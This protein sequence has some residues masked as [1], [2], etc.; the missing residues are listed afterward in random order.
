[1]PAKLLATASIGRRLASIAY[2]LLLIAAILL[3]SSALYTPIKAWANA[4]FWLDQLFRLFLIGIL[5]AYFGVCW[6]THGQ[7]VAMKAWR[8]KLVTAQGTPLSWRHASLRYFIGLVLF[9]GVPVL[10]YLSTSHRY[11]HTRLVAV[12]SSLWALLPFVAASF[13]PEH[14]PLHDRLAGTRL[15]LTPTLRRMLR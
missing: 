1:M 8:L 7:T 6:V 15:I 9:I 11:G 4:S 10:A 13:D 12:L 5:F 3:T 14:Q 2:E